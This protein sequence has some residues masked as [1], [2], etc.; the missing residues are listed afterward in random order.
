MIIWY[1]KHYLLVKNQIGDYMDEK[2]NRRDIDEY[3]EEEYECGI[4]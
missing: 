2:K 4:L 3:H 1:V